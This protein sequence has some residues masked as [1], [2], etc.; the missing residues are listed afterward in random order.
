MRIAVISKT[1]IPNVIEKLRS[2]RTIFVGAVTQDAPIGQQPH[3]DRY[4]RPRK[5]GA[6]KAARPSANRD[7]SKPR[8]RGRTRGTGECGG[9]TKN[10]VWPCSTN[11]RAWTVSVIN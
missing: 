5:R 7:S 10:E 3:V 8:F 4:D 1:G 9:L 6:K 11:S 2:L